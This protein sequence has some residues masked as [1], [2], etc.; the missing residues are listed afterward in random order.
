MFALLT[1]LLSLVIASF[2]VSTW[3]GLSQV[4]SSSTA[5]V[6]SLVFAIAGFLSLLAQVAIYDCLITSKGFIRKTIE[7]WLVVAIIN[8]IVYVWLR[9]LS[10][11][12]MPVNNTDAIWLGFLVVIMA[13]VSVLGLFEMNK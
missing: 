5:T 9:I 4:I 13:V 10:I 8:F 3:L 6:L 7:F 2:Y 12:T 11:I 1:T